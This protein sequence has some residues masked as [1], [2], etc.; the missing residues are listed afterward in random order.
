MAITHSCWRLQGRRWYGPL[1]LGTL[2]GR[3]WTLDG[4]VWTLDSKVWTLGGN[5]WTLDGRIFTSRGLP[6][7]TGSTCVWGERRWLG[8]HCAVSNFRA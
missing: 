3:I 2:D 4:K 6:E 1:A 8:R 7:E 5:V